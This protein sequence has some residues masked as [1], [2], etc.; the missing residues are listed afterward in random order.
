MAVDDLNK[1]CFTLLRAIQPAGAAFAANVRHLLD[2]EVHWITWKAKGCNAFDK[3]PAAKPSDGPK[4][5]VGVGGKRKKMSLGT[6]ELSRLWNLGGN[7]LAEISAAVAEKSTVPPLEHYL[8]PVLVQMDP[9]EGIEEAYRHKNDKVYTWKAMRLM[10]KKDASL[11]GCFAKADKVTKEPIGSLETA[12]AA[13]GEKNG[14]KV[15][16]LPGAQKEGEEEKSGADE[17]GEGD[18][19]AGGGEGGATPA[20][21]LT[22]ADEMQVG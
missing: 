10:A 1:R 16:Q 13:W 14:K 5:R 17:K 6:A 12:A 22:P 21:P 2:R 3:P 8:D 9:D 18:E 7:S 20:A 19:K 11:I 4:R 15:P